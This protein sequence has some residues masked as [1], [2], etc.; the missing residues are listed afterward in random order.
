MKRPWTAAAI[1]GAMLLFAAAVFPLLPE[2]IPT[3]WNAGGQIDGWGSRWMAFM[4]PALGAGLVLLAWGLPKIDPRR[5]NFARFRGT[6]WLIFNL[7]LL[8]LLTLE[9]LTLGVALGWR[10]DIGTAVN[11]LTG[12]LFIGLG[13]V[14]PRLRPDWWMGIRTPWTLESDRVWREAHR[15]GGRVFVA[16]GVVVALAA[17][18]PPTLR[19]ASIIG[20]VVAAALG[21]TI[22]SYI[23][24][25]RER[26]NPPEAAA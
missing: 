4:H 6:Y 21:T 25:R 22:Y 8:F 23:A 18:A 9:V 19:I 24:W 16:A 14:L 3:H 10:V 26:Q 12:V 1:V 2:A 17:F 15:M 7:L 5:E 11:L 13:N 20:A